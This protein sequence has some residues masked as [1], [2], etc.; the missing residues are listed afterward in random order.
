MPINK[1]MDKQTTVDSY[2]SV[3][4]EWK[5]QQRNTHNNTDESKNILDWVRKARQKGGCMCDFYWL[6]TKPGTGKMLWCW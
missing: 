3:T 2:N 1:R 4:Q 5:Q 6:E